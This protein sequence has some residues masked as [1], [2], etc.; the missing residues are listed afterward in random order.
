MRFNDADIRAIAA[1][2]IFEKEFTG[3]L[4]KHVRG[5]VSSKYMAE[6][7]VPPSYVDASEA[8]AGQVLTKGADGYASWSD[9]VTGL[10]TTIG[11]FGWSDGTGSQTIPM[12]DTSFTPEVI[13]FGTIAFTDNPGTVATMCFGADTLDTYKI[14]TAIR[15][16]SAGQYRAF[17]DSYSM[18]ALESNSVT[19]GVQGYVTAFNQGEFVINKV[20]HTGDSNPVFIYLAMAVG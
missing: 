9:G 17:S 10:Q 20:T 2:H 15:I 5:N 1:S 14:G 18:L 12:N 8:T 4:R 13:L 19:P 11:S 3:L 7:D 16:T 6:G